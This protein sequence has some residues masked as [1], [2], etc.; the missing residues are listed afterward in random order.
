M[1]FEQIWA[2]YPRKI[3]KKPSRDQWLKLTLEQQQKALQALP[4][5]IAYWQAKETD[6]EFIPHLRTWLY[7][8]RFEDE[9]E[10]PKPKQEAVQWWGSEAGILA[11]GQEFGVLPRPGEDMFQYKGRLFEAIKKSA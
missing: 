4:N 5:H 8:E 3:A 2:L 6:K 7:Q 1:D 10:M 9:I 11:K